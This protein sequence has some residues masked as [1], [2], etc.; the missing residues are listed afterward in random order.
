MSPSYSEGDDH[1]PVARS[2]RAQYRM[3]V[4]GILDSFCW[5]AWFDNFAIIPEANG[6]TTLIGEVTDQAA[7][8]GL[9]SRV[10]DLGLTLVAVERSKSGDPEEDV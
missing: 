1:R 5:G 7:L 4:Q 8:Y 10:R 3:R 2:E 9:I 6:D